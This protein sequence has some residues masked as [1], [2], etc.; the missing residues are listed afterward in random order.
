MTDLSAFEPNVEAVAGY[1]PDLVVTD[2]TNPDFLSQLDS[3]GLDHWEGPAPM[4]FGDVY[5]QIEQLGAIDRARRRGRRAGRPDAGRHRRD[6]RR[7][8]GARARR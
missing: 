4:G 6:R 3:L 7:D 1:E 5:A 8:A 2:G